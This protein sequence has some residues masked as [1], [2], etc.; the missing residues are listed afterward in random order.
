MRR[1]K[2]VQT[3]DSPRNQKLITF[4]STEVVILQDTMD[5]FSKSSSAAK[6]VNDENQK[7]KC[8]PP[9]SKFP[10]GQKADRNI[11]L[12]KFQASVKPSLDQYAYVPKP[13]FFYGILMD[14]LRL[15]EVLQ[16]SATP[17]LKPAEVNSYKIMLWGQYPALIDGP[18]NSCVSGMGYVVETEEQHKMPEY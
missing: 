6:I 8:S 4:D 18:I 1:F 9:T 13:F 3:K 15:Q 14:P 10:P 17:V 2:K 7:P 12:K 16:L 11:I 5:S